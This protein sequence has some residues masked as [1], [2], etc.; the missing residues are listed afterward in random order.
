[1]EKVKN[2]KGQV[3]ILYSPEYGAGW[4]TWNTEYPQMIFCPE[5][6]NAVLKCDE[7]SLDECKKIDY[8]TPIAEKLFPYAS[9][10]GLSGLEVYWLE[11]GTAFDIE[12]YDDGYESIKIYGSCLCA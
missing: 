8:L 10:G 7:L 2:D 12:E 4:Y 6:V 9:L 3:A 5:L 11:A 1:M